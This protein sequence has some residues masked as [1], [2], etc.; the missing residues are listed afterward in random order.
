MRMFSKLIRAKKSCDNLV[1]I[2]ILLIKWQT[3]GIDG[4]HRCLINYFV[5]C[6]MYL[7]VVKSDSLFV[8]LIE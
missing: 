2:D 8:I 4:V 3:L 5:E 7:S 1:V 6:E